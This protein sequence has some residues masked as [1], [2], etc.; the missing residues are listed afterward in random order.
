MNVIIIPTG[1][2]IAGDHYSLMCSLSGLE[3]DT[4][5]HWVRGSSDCSNESSHAHTMNSH[6]MTFE[7]LQ[8]QNAG[9]YTCCVQVESGRTTL[10]N[11]LSVFH[12]SVGRKY[13]QTV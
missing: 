11:I 1:S 2:S 7:R 6:I 10:Y 9:N 13:R 4:S 5:V 8:T 12:L 3:S